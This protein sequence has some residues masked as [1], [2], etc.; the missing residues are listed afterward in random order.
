MMIPHR[1]SRVVAAVG[2]YYYYYWRCESSSVSARPTPRTT[3]VTEAPWELKRK[4]RRMTHS[5]DRDAIH[6][7]AIAGPMRVQD[8]VAARFANCCKLDWNVHP[9]QCTLRQGANDLWPID[10]CNGCTVGRLGQQLELVP[11]HPIASD[12]PQ[13]ST[14]GFVGLWRTLTMMPVLPWQG[15]LGRFPK[16]LGNFHPRSDAWLDASGPSNR[17]HPMK[18]SWRWGTCCLLGRLLFACR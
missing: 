7:T 16:Q 11:Y 9:M 4:R 12:M 6:A 10:C 13:C 5:D 17:I 2:Y 18:L 3:R 15:R 1:P 8:R 14:K